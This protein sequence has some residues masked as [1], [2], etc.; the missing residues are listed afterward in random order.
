MAATT[1]RFAP[2]VYWVRRR[3]RTYSSPGAPSMGDPSVIARNCGNLDIEI[4]QAA[5]TGK[6][7]AQE[8]PKYTGSSPPPRKTVVFPAHGIEQKGDHDEAHPSS[9]PRARGG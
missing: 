5:A 9:L 8:S 6:R 4:W 7:V 3:C 1:L 2:T